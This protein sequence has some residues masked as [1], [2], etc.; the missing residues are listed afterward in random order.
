MKKM[1][2]IGCL[3]V[4][5]LLPC[6]SLFAFE[7]GKLQINGFL[8]Q[9]YLDSSNNNFLDPGSRDGTFQL[10]EVG[11]TFNAPISEKLRIGAQFLSRDMGEE[12]NNEVTLDWAYGD[13]RFADWFG[14]RAGKIKLPVGLYNES[15]DS[16]FL[17]SMAFLPQSVYDE[18]QRSFMGAGLGAGLYGNVPAGSLGDFDYQ[19]FYGQNQV[20]EDIL[21][22]DEGLN[23]Q[24]MDNLVRSLSG[25]FAN[26]D[27][28]KYEADYA[29]AASLI[30]NTP[31]DGLRLGASYFKT[32][33]KF[34]V[35]VDEPA[36][37]FESNY[38]VTDYDVDANYNHMYVLSAE[39]AQPLYSLHAEYMQRENDIKAPG[40]APVVGSW[41]DFSTTTSEGWYVM[42]TCQIPQVPGL[43][44]SALYDVFYLD[45]DDKDG[46]DRGFH[47]NGYRKDFGVGARYDINENWLVKAEWHTIDGTALNTDIVNTDGPM[48]EDWSYFIVKT[49]F[50]F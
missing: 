50:N 37:F 46:K 33:G 32:H 23:S 47:P 41:S 44:V 17:R 14:V 27:D 19:L 49:S 22:V 26:V 35:S 16:D 3:L 38:G 11:L 15:R 7:L 25:G 4:L 10:N 48:D 12:G 24:G 31:V 21:L 20:D 9:G 8:S 28:F 45:K 30:Y 18:M 29:M 36:G 2:I 43:S 42:A 34:K 40:F 1:R 6:S 13:Y 5:A 39:Y